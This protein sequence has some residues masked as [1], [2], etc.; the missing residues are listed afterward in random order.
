[1]KINKRLLTIALPIVT[2]ITVG[3]ALLLVNPH[4][5][6]KVGSVIYS[7]GVSVE[8]Y[9]Y[10]V[11]K[12]APSVVNIYV[13]S[14]NEDYT[15]PDT[16]TITSSASGVIMSDLGYIVTNY[17]VVP[18]GN[19]PNK[20]IWVQTREGKV[21]KAFIVGCD[22]RTDI[23][24]LKV[25]EKNLPPIHIAKRTPNIGDI[26]LAIGN[27]NNLGQTVTHGI[28]SALSRSGTGLI[29]KE[30]MSIRQG[31]QDLIQTDAPINQGNSGGALIDTQGNLIGINTASFST[32]DSYGIGFSVPVNLVTEVM[33]EIIMH[34]KV[35][36][37]YLGISDSRIRSLNNQKGV[38]VEFIDPQGPAFGILKSGDV[39]TKVN[40]KEIVDAK[41]LI[42]LVSKTKPGTTLRFE[43][44][45][46]NKTIEESVTLALD[47]TSLD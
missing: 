7:S 9:S 44:L 38:T 31:L 22:R 40:S 11:S 26:V 18:L 14:L 39:L 20:A 43:I 13:A 19:E 12:A 35:E 41:Q 21:L 4:L 16:T 37:G 15:E 23:A 28:I 1:M 32:Q 17:H 3:C 8:G 2:G 25:E 10:A 42:E 24:V 36:R 33:N 47:K 27:P 46:N 30:Q 45:R 34:G 5:G 29:S 6:K